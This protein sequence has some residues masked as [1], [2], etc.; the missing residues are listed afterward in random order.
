M[1]ASGNVEIVKAA[2]DCFNRGDWDAALEYATDD[3]EFD[4]TRAIGPLHGVF[5]REAMVGFLAE[6]VEP[7]DEVRFDADEYIEVGDHVLT[8]LTNYHRGRQ[9]IEI[10]GHAHQL[11][12]FRDGKVARICFFPNRDQALA[13]A[14]R[15]ER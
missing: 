8:P 3:F 4:L 6:L 15:V 14:G 13:A 9:G 12:T 10:E 7:W 5:G 2:M 1:T 11:W